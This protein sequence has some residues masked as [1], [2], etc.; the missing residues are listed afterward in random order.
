MEFPNI[1]VLVCKSQFWQRLFWDT[2]NF[3]CKATADRSRFALA[4]ENLQLL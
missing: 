3:D 2:L 4:T 1:S